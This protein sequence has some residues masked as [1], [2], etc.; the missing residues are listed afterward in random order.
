ML[1]RYTIELL[2]VLHCGMGIHADEV[3]RIGGPGALVRFNKVSAV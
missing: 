1:G 2:L 3:V